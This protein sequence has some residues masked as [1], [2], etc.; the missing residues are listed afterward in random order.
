V[1]A[2]VIYLRDSSLVKQESLRGDSRLRYDSTATA[3]RS[4]MEMFTQISHILGMGNTPLSQPT[5]SQ[6]AFKL[7]T[8]VPCFTAIALDCIFAIDLGQVRLSGVNDSNILVRSMT[9]TF[10]LTN[11][12]HNF[13]H[14]KPFSSK[15]RVNIKECT[16]YPDST[17]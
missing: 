8:T 17:E 14:T 12:V 2:G 7:A 3:F 16:D 10:A 5:P 1:F 4:V 15:A 9:K 13:H 6:A 11:R